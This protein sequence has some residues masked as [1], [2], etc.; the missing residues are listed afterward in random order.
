MGEAKRKEVSK[1]EAL[2]EKKKLFEK[3]PQLKMP[4]HGLLVKE[5]ARV[6]QTGGEWS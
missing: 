6:W 4:E 3:D 2:E 5:L 1:E